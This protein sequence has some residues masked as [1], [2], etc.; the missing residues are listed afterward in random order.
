MEITKLISVYER[1]LPVYKKAYEENWDYL[2]LKSSYLVCG[3]CGASNNILGID[4][5][6][7]FVDYYYDLVDKDGYLFPRHQKGRDLKSRIDFMES[8]I[9]DLKKLLKKGYTHV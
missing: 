8:E 1:L 5:F 4:L 6:D 3:I 7:L 9:K 2:D